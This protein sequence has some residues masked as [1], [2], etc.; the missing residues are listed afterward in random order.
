MYNLVMNPENAEKNP[1]Q[2]KPQKKS[3]WKETIREIVFFVIIAVGIVL[4]FRV[5]VAEPYLVDG[6]S[7]DPTFKSG[8]YLIVNK[9]VYRFKEPER[10][11]VIV[12]KYPNDPKKSFIKRIVG[13]PNETIEVKDGKTTIYNS[14]FPQGF[15]VDQSYVIYSSPTSAKKTL[16]EEE[17]FVMGDN[18]AE[19]FDSRAWGILPKQNIL[20]EPLFRLWPIN[21]IKVFP[22]Q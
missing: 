20:G 19:S 5:Y 9:L 13:L 7:M 8:D 4:P 11:S 22:G 10:N 3:F 12:F 14:E 16:S 6:R 18:R 17:Y 2:A 21:K 1:P 15:Q